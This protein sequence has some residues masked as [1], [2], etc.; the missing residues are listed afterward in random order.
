MPGAPADLDWD[1]TLAFRHHI[2]SW[3]LGVADAMDTAQRNM[4]L[5]PKATR[6]LIARSAAEA[7]TVGGA[8]VV[9]VNTDHVEDEVLS[10]QEVID[11]YVE[12][13]HFAEDHGAG[14]VLMASRHLARA[15]TSPADYAHVYREVLRRA[16]RPGHPAL[17]GRGV[18]P[19]ARRLL[20]LAR[21]P[22]PHRH[23][24]RASSARTSTA[25]GASR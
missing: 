17:A 3:G 23:R 16:G 15:A 22:E 13:L 1:A 7:R 20:R 25:S 5:D 14:T 11:A 19:A 9:G 8:L 18:R 12:Q 4:G 21:R 2:W 24:S 6:E 10:L